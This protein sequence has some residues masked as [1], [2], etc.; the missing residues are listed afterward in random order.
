[1]GRIKRAVKIAL[2]ALIL[3]SSGKAVYLKYQIESPLKAFETAGV[4]VNESL[5]AVYHNGNTWQFATYREED[6]RIIV[7]TVS[8]DFIHAFFTWSLSKNTESSK[9][10][11]NYSPLALDKTLLKKYRPHHRALLFKTLGWVYDEDIA[12]HLPALSEVMSRGEK[13]SSITGL[14]SNRGLWINMKII[15]DPPSLFAHDYVCRGF[16]GYDGLLV[17]PGYR[18]K[19][20]RMVWVIERPQGDFV[21]VTVFYPGISL[22][23]L[24]KPERKINGTL[25]FTGRSVQL[26]REAVP[27]YVERDILYIELEVMDDRNHSSVGGI[28]VLPKDRYGTFDESWEGEEE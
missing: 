20:G 21:N 8:W 22:S 26:L 5:I 3:I 11:F 17:I 13:Y 28:F 2:L 6:N 4:A 9:A 23:K 18:L 1:M 7:R 14:G 12:L 10:A 27:D 15:C 24:V 16:I 25:T 19:T